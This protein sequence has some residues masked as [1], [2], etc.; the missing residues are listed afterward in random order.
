MLAAKERTTP[1]FPLA[2]ALPAAQNGFVSSNLS[3][4][5]HQGV[6]DPNAT[7]HQAIAFSKPLIA[8]GL[9]SCLYDSGRR[10]R[11][12]GKERDAWGESQLDYFGARWLSSLQGRWTTPDD[13][14][15]DQDPA[16]PQSWNLYTYGR[17]N[18]LSFIDPDGRTT[19]DADGNNC[20]DDITVDGG[21]P[22]YVPYLL[23]R[24]TWGYAKMQAG[25]TLQN[26]QYAGQLAAHAIQGLGNYGGCV[27]GSAGTWGAAGAAGGATAGGVAGL[28]TAGLAEW[29]T[30]S[31]GALVGSL[32][33]AA[34]GGVVGAIHCSTGTGPTGGGESA[35]AGEGEVGSPQ[36]KKLTPGE[37][38]KL[39]ATSGES[40]HQIKTEALGTNK[41]IAQ[42]D[43]YKDAQG[44][45]LVK[46]K[47]GVGEAIPTGLKIN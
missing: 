20:H 37:I 4:N 43:L 29:A 32:G 41:G 5:S 12:T 7:L 8:P 39:E 47:G 25:K 1:V 42:Y 24:V 44:N 36:D 9:P 15:N 40:A 13:P 19:C 2:A 22:D 34:A 38:R 18:P 21:G 23:L 28:A 11:C 33:G 3:E 26:L 10:S 31:T 35:G 46:A 16:E 27:L 17:N 30:V 45:V 14:F 6:R